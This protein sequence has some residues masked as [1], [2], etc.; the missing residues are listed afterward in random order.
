MDTLWTNGIGEPYGAPDIL[1][2]QHGVC[3]TIG[4]HSHDHRI[5]P[6]SGRKSDVTRV[7]TP[8]VTPGRS[9]CSHTFARHAPASC[10][11]RTCGR[12]ICVEPNASTHW[13][14]MG[15]PGP[16]ADRNP[17]ARC[18][19]GW[20][21]RSE[22]ARAKPRGADGAAARSATVGERRRWV[23]HLHPERNR[24]AA[25]VIARSEA[26]ICHCEERSDDLS[27]R[28]AKR[29]SNPLPDEPPVTHQAGSAHQ[30][31]DCFVASL[32]PTTG[33]S[34]CFHSR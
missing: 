6:E 11:G 34:R 17:G 19:T 26:T 29:Q 23:E 28:G 1:G 21:R 7:P 33:E 13:Q 22:R 8:Q 9:G 18:R 25:S 30:A 4:E 12:D 27:L 24:H 32:L 15:R 5:P 16:S 10:W 3:R 14:H 31:G 2:R 20:R